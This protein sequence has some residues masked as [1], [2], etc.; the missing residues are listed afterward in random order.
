MLT[1]CASVLSHHL[2]NCVQFRNLWIPGYVF[3]ATD[4]KLISSTFGFDLKRVMNIRRLGSEMF[5][6]DGLLMQ[7]VCAGKM[8]TFPKVEAGK[9]YYFCTCGRSKNQPWW[10]WCKEKVPLCMSWCGSCMWLY[11]TSQV[12]RGPRWHLFH[13][14]S[15]QTWKKWCVPP[16]PHT[17]VPNRI[18]ILSLY[19]AFRAAFTRHFGTNSTFS[20]PLPLSFTTLAL[21]LAQG[22]H[23]QEH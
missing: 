3:A 10:D 19:P 6:F 21:R 8:P 12:W 1:R 18:P 22:V 13:S 20:A 11:C 14:P 9:D 16:L 4:K 5:S 7:V 17:R 23:V 2:H 15:V